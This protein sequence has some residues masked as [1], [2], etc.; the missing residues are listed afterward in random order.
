MKKVAIIGANGYTGVELIRLLSNHPEVELAAITSNSKEGKK[1]TDVYPQFSGLVDKTFR[2]QNEVA[3]EVYDIV[4]LALPHGA[5]MDFL[6]NYN[7]HAKVIDLSADFRL[8]D[9]DVFMKWYKTEHLFPEKLDE[10]VYGLTEINRNEIKKA[11]FIAN[12]GCY[13][14]A[15]ALALAPLVQNDLVIEDSIIIDAKSGVTGAGARPS[16]NTHYSRVND[17]FAAYA[18]A[19]HRHTPEI[20]QTL[21][22]IGG[23]NYLVQFT[24]HL[25]PLNRGILATVYAKTKKEVGDLVKLYKEF[26]AEDKYVVVRDEVPSLKDVKGSNFCHIHPQYDERTGRVIIVS[27]IDN[28][29]KG[30][31]GQ[32][33]QNMNVMMG[34]DES[35]GIHQV[36]LSI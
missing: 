29:V 11:N 15:C 12:P 34:W 28:L 13:P 18:V 5:T 36:A 30:A 9:K 25:L 10:T 22:N 14:T 17:N 31:S 3:N 27:V 33:I 4:F 19:T 8:E 21:S 20:E 24:P 1:L 23:R 7:G 26:Y 32:A 2:N 16:D 6:K 35:T